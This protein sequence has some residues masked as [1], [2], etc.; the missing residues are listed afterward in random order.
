MNINYEI[1]DASQ[2]YLAIFWKDKAKRCR[3]AGRLSNRFNAVFA[4]NSRKNL[5]W[6]GSWVLN[7]REFRIAGQ[8]RDL[9]FGFGTEAEKNQNRCFRKKEKGILWLRRKPC[10]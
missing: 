9:I 3:K 5:T 2:F 10:L 7:L 6:F 8:N 1:Q 4:K